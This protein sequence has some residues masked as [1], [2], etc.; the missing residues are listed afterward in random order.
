MLR[1]V[2][3]TT[4]CSVQ[5]SVARWHFP[6]R[7][8]PVGQ[9]I[10]AYLTGKHDLDPTSVHLMFAANRH[11]KK[12]ACLPE[13][14]RVYAFGCS[15]VHVAMPVLMAQS[16]HADAPTHACIIVRGCK[17]AS[18]EAVTCAT[19]QMRCMRQVLIVGSGSA[20]SHVPTLKRLAPQSQQGRGPTLPGQHCC[21][22]ATPPLRLTSPCPSRPRP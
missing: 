5:R 10:N 16:A 21:S 1:V 11:E 14:A 15:C 8:T 18:E 4:R 9:A 12:W 19:W 2:A 17:V 6:D 13:L 7:T 22:C 20:R 3:T